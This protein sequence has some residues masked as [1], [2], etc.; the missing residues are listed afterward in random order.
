M[1]DDRLRDVFVYVCVCVCVCVCEVYE[2]HSLK[3][4]KYNIPKRERKRAPGRPWECKGNNKKGSRGAD[5][6][7][8]II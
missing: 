8:N 4:I 6:A 2:I 1:L 5:E 3:C 7:V